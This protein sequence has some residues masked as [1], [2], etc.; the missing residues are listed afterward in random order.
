M[1]VKRF[2]FR[3]TGADTV[4]QRVGSSYG[5]AGPAACMTAFFIRARRTEAE[6]RA[7]LALD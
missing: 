7:P 5:K 1:P 6:T 3:R 4:W 2:R